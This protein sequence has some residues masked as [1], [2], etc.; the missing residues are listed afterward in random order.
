MSAN[1]GD[2]VSANGES[3]ANITTQKQNEFAKTQNAAKAS[4]LAATAAHSSIA[5]IA[6]CSIPLRSLPLCS[7]GAEC[8]HHPDA[9]GG[10]CPC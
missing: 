7:Q 5:T 4:D 8:N 10:N 3:A 2:E 6:A 1:C 9:P